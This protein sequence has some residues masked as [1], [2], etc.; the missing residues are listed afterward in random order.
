MT[1]DLTRLR[2]LLPGQ[3]V[4]LAT[5]LAGILEAYP[6]EIVTARRGA[7]LAVTTQL[8]DAPGLRLRLGIEPIPPLPPPEDAA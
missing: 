3:A 6:G 5:L 7:I 1:D 2:A 4:H 8:P